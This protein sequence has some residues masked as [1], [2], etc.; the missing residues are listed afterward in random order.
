MAYLRAAPASS[1]LPCRSTPDPPPP[2]PADAAL[3]A[4]LVEDLWLR[5]HTP[6]NDAEA[7]HCAHEQ[8]GIYDS[9]RVLPSK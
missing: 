5:F 6:A 7:Q 8:P 1:Q 4:E 3:P 2:P 9:G